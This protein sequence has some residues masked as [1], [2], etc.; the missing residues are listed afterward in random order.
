M[1]RR[2]PEH[3]NLEYYQKRA[4]R[5]LRAESTDERPAHLGQAQHR[6]AREAGFDCWADLAAAVLNT[7]T[8][9]GAVAPE[10]AAGRAG[11]EP[12]A[13]SHGT[14]VA[15]S[16]P[17]GRVAPE[18]GIGG[19][20][21]HPGDEHGRSG[22]S[23]GSSS[24][25]ARIGNDPVPG[26]NHPGNPAPPP[27]RVKQ[28]YESERTV[29]RWLADRDRAD[30]FQP[31]LLVS[32]ADRKWVAGA[33]GPF[34]AQGLISDVRN[35]IKSGKEA[36]VYRCTVADGPDLAAKVYRP[37]VQFDFAQAVDASSGR[38][39]RLLLERDLEALAGYF[40]RFGQFPDPVATAAEIWARTQAETPRLSTR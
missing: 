3:P 18:H 8:A 31:S 16:H 29:Q 23:V 40:S 12:D 22:E 34:H 14:G 35:E 28:R 20:A 7:V 38:D 11:G 5:L 6:V 17:G 2:L 4:K 36:T 30:G 13:P 9:R 10:P 19:A 15:A 25:D 32:S 33:L 21:G 39:A 1:D 24:S 26:R 37:R 27:S